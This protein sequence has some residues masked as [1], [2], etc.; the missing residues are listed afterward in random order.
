MNL[1]HE[2]GL[3]YAKLG[4]QI[5]A[6][7]PGFFRTSLAGELRDRDFVDRVNKFTPMGRELEPEPEEIRGPALAASDGSC[8][9]K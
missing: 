4:I 2:S 5:N 6:P 7:C 1:T 8:L 3:K 9:A